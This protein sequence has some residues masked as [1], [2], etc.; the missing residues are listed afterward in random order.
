MA[1]IWIVSE[2][3]AL[4]TTLAHHVDSLG[5]VW[6]GVPEPAGFK[7]APPP[8]LLILCGVAE[9]SDRHDALERLLAFV[10]QIP[11]RRRASAPVLYLAPDGEPDG[12]LHLERL[13]DDRCFSLLRFPFD[14]DELTARARDLLRSSE[15][16]ESLRERARK[17]WVTHEVER[18]YAGLD[19]PE[20]RQAVDPRN[21][22]RPV[23]LIGEPGTRRALLA[24]YVHN[25]AEPTR[26][27]FVS[28]ALRSMAIG[29]LESVIMTRTTNRRATAYLDGLDDAAPA[30]QDELAHLLGAS[31][32]LALEPLRWIAAATRGGGFARRA[33]RSRLAARRA[34]SAPR[35]RATRPR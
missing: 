4:S 12:G 9:R 28:I 11:Q 5:G 35:T 20:L 30:L 33:S 2:E 22:H 32:A 7:S 18:L 29:E 24:R 19:L 6:L 31:G 1:A 10:R 34:S 14:P 23:L 17:L 13:F 3:S 26:D 27:A 15:R 8:D 16:P 25:L 21:A